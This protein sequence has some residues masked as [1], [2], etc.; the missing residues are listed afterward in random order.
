MILP[1]PSAGVCGENRLHLKPF[2]AFLLEVCDV[3][4]WNIEAVLKK[5]FI[6]WKNEWSQRLW[7]FLLEKQVVL[8]WFLHRG[9]STLPN[10]KDLGT[11]FAASLLHEMRCKPGSKLKDAPLFLD[12]MQLIQ[13]VRDDLDDRWCQFWGIFLGEFRW[14]LAGLASRV[15]SKNRG[16]K[17]CWIF[18]IQD[19]ANSCSGICWRF[20]E[21]G[22]VRVLEILPK[23]LFL[24]PIKMK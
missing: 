16:W 17:P 15:R 5:R 24:N 20:A 1:V 10:W 8:V 11:T 14:H 23:T 18:G 3:F 7:I 12:H 4:F 9:V 19:D 22:N 6:S 21:I 2:K 13:K